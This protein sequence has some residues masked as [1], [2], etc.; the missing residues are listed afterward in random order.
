VAN[1]P[2]C[3]TGWA[4]YAGDLRLKNTGIFFRMGLDRTGKSLSRPSP[5]ISLR[6]IRATVDNLPI[7]RARARVASSG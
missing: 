6:P 5:R 3:G 2:S 7:A 1:V 4:D